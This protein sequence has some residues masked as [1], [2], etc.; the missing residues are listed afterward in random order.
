MR[1]G[2]GDA[3]GV[4]HRVRRLD[5]LDSLAGNGRGRSGSPPGRTARPASSPRAPWPSPPMP[6]RRRSPA[7]GHAAPRQVRRQAVRR[8][9]S[10]DRRREQLREQVRFFPTAERRVS[11]VQA[12]RSVG[13]VLPSSTSLSRCRCTA[14]TATSLHPSSDSS[15]D[16]LNVHTAADGP[17]GDSKGANESVGRRIS[18]FRPPCAG[19]ASSAFPNRLPTTGSVA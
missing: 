7:V 3:G 5:D 11:L 6:C 10:G 9:G 17:R 4:G 8:L 18:L 1:C 13:S 12:C 2:R 14:P 15:G 19:V 16:L